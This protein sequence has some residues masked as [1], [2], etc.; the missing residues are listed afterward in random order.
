MDYRVQ[1][2]GRFRISILLRV[3]VRFMVRVRARVRVKVQNGLGFGLGLGLSLEQ[4]LGSRFTIRVRHV[5]IIREVREKMKWVKEK[6]RK[7]EEKGKKLSY[8]WL[9]NEIHCRYLSPTE[10][11]ENRIKGILNPSSS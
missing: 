11:G 8:G 4:E 6:K 7:N 1:I 2:G 5:K 10:D 9:A 3:R